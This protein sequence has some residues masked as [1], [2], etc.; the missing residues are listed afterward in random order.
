M[1]CY[2]TNCTGLVVLNQHEFKLPMFVVELVLVNDNSKFQ[3]YTE[4][5]E[6]K[7]GIDT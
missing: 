7:T 5:G 2:V 4:A 6:P 1:C 3:Q